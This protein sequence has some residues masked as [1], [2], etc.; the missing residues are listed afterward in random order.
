MGYLAFLAA[1]EP[2]YPTL[3]RVVEELKQELDLSK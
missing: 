3:V 2:F 1:G